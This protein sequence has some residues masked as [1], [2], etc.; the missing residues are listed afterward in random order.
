MVRQTE[1][2]KIAEQNLLKTVLGPRGERNA[3]IRKE[4]RSAFKLSLSKREE[5]LLEKKRAMLE[6]I[7]KDAG[8]GKKTNR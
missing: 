4:D 2:Q 3:L 5:L 1:R 6:G 8:K 7:R